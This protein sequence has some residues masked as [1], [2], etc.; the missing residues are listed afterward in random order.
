[1]QINTNNTDRV[2]IKLTP[3]ETV[4]LISELSNSL[5]ILSRSDKCEKHVATDDFDIEIT[6]ND[7]GDITSGSIYFTISDL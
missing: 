1:M 6:Q 5:V 2:I 3:E 4:K 7:Y